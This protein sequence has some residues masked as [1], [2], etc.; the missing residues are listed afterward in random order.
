V[1]GGYEGRWAGW[2]DPDRAVPLPEPL[3]PLLQA[4][5]ARAAPARTE[6]ADVVLPPSRLPETAERALAAIVGAEHVRTDAASRARH[7]AGKSTPDLVR[8]RAGRAPDPPDAVVHPVS[9]DEVLAVLAACTEHRVAAVPFG[10]GTSVVGGL[11]TGPGPAVALDLGRLDRL[12]AVDPVARTATFQAGVRAPDADRLLAAH[13]YTLGHLPQSYEY[14]TI[15]GF[16]ATRSSGQASAGYGRFDDMVVGLTVA[17]P[18]GALDLGRAPASAAGPDLR[19]LFLG[20]EGA[21]GVVTSVTLRIRPRPA[22]QRY[23]GWRFPSF[24]AGTAAVRRL[25]QDGPLPDVVRL[26]DGYET[27]LTAPGIDGCL[28]IAGGGADAGAALRAAGGTSLGAEPGEA[29]AAGRFAAPYLRDALLDAGAFAETLETATFWSGL[30]GLY[31]ATRGALLDA[32][33]PQPRIVLCHVSHV[34]E[35]GASLY[36]TVLFALG[37]DP[38][39]RW[40]AAKARASDAILDSGGTISHHHGVGT[41]HRDWY[42]REVGPLAVDLLRAVKSTV[43]PAGILNP[44]VLLP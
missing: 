10:G 34:Y 1:V 15:G 2:G 22:N 23:E 27:A 14:A 7:S 8:Q 18:A 43:D 31:A 21:L 33:A 11:A 6:L 40:A 25:A 16:A 32:L 19:Q 17:T 36:F 20:S 35:T 26:S 5:G 12:L 38:L 24:E 30:P 13:G 3:R 44:G 39:E 9:H 37:D 41:A 29:W 42:R 28:L 4:L